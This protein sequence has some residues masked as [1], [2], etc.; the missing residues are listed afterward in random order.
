LAEKGGRVFGRALIAFLVLPGLAAGLIPALISRFDPWRVD[1]TPIGY[2]LL[3]FGLTLLV[4]C[5]RDFYVSGK[6]TLAPWDPPRS[7]VIVGLYRF[8]RNPMYVCVLCILL[9]WC[10]ISGSAVMVVYIFFMAT[11]FHLRVTRNEEL[12][13]KREFGADWAVYAATVN[14]WW[15]R[16]KPH[17]ANPSQDRGADH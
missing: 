7:L 2:F 9:G 8:V 17:S 14:R 10:L 15:P 11:M 3:V 6:G 4:W 16:L 12:W 5:V 13:L 1:G